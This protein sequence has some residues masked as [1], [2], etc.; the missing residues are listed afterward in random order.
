[1]EFLLLQTC[2]R[3]SADAAQD[4]FGRRAEVGLRGVVFGAEL[5]EPAVELVVGPADAVAGVGVVRVAGRV[6]AGRL[7]D[8]AARRK[9]PGSAWGAAF[10]LFG[11]GL[12][13]WAQ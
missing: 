3:V 8:D 10:R 5:L 4:G 9:R 12:G 13:G 1:M 11:N 7:G 2:R 6:V